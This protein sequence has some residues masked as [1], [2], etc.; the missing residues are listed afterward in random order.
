MHDAMQSSDATVMRC[1]AL[2]M[3]IRS[4]TTRRRPQRR[5]GFGSSK[6]G[7]RGVT[8]ASKQERRFSLATQV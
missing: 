2:R 8:A 4:G 5:T 3:R 1:D 7:P 6:L